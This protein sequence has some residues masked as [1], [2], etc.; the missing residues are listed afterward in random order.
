MVFEAETMSL[1]P[2]VK[3]N[4]L[5]I[6]QHSVGSECITAAWTLEKINYNDLLSNRSEL[7]YA[8]GI[9]ASYC[10]TLSILDAV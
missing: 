4:V 7:W 1:A 2:F 6:V 8:L 3:C 9:L 10:N 5:Y